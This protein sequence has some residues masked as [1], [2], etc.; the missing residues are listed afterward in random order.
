MHI[1][2]SPRQFLSSVEINAF[3]W[4]TLT[5]LGCALPRCV[6]GEKSMNACLWSGR[7]RVTILW[8]HRRLP[9]SK[10]GLMTLM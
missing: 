4:L 7:S 1:I 3:E 2:A 9:C 6:E 8:G 5:S 10:L